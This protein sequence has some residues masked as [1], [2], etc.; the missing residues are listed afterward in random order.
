MHIHVRSESYIISTQ[1]RI[2]SNEVVLVFLSLFIYFERKRESTQA[3]EGEREGQTESQAG[4]MPST[5]SPMWGS[6]PLTVR[7]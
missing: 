7:S 2:D 3:E 5:Q 1:W 6:N 4:S